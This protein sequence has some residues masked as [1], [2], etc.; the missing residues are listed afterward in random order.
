MFEPSGAD[1]ISQ[2]WGIYSKEAAEYDSE[3][4]EKHRNNMDIALIFAGLFSAVCTSFIIAMQPSLSPDP[5]ETTNALLKILIHT[6][7][8]STFSDRDAGL[9]QWDGAGASTTWAQTLA[10][11]SL[12][13]S[14]FA[15]LGAVL[16][17][18]W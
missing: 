12:S 3:F 7:D 5:A 4:L 9:P 16:G 15:A 14:L 13:T 18:Q 1:N 6:I 10:Y 11:G 2:F 8:N 17:K